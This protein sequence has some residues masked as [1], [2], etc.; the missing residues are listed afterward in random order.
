MKF[1]PDDALFPLSGYALLS[2]PISGAVYIKL[3]TLI[4]PMTDQ[5]QELPAI[6]LTTSQAK[7]L[8]NALI[9]AAEKSSAGTNVPQNLKN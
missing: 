8:A 5:Q 6:A 3:A 4:S 2:D 7:E 9:A 1:N